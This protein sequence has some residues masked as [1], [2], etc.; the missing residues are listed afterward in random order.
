MSQMEAAGMADQP[1]YAALEAQKAQLEGSRQT[2]SASGAR[3]AQLSKYSEG[4]NLLCNQSSV[5]VAPVVGVDYRLG[6]WNF[7]A[8]YEFK[9]QIR[10]KNESTVFDASEIDAVIKY[11]DSESVNE[12]QPAL[13]TLG[14]QW[15]A[16]DEIRFNA[17]WHHYFDKDAEWYNNTQRLLNYDTNEFLMG[18][19]WDVNDRL[20]LS[21]GAQ[22]TR[23]GLTDQY[24]NDMS[25]VTSS[26]SIGL[27]GNYK[28]SDVV[29][30]KAGYFTT[31]Y[32][33]YERKDYPVAGVADT[34]TRTNK[35]LGIG[36]DI[37]L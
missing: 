8:K 27:G 18:A 23:Y 5:G 36:C 30:L 32:E 10:M 7:A 2:L 25:F 31:S 12:D 22:L 3:L 14:V 33:N 21:L 29:T 9:T 13:L 19:E 17:G 16:I 37:N 4:V 6:R 28:L 24:M 35:V 20:T 11:R 1:Q 26:Y 34:F 15:N